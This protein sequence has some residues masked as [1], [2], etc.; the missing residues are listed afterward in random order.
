VG[1]LVEGQATEVTLDALPNA[2]LTGSVERIAPAA[3]FE[4]GV[5]YY[6]VVI[7]LDPTDVPVRADMTASATV[8]IDELPDVLM[9]PT[10]VVRV[11]QDTGQTYVD[12]QIGDDVERVDV[13]LG[14][15]HEGVAQVLS[16]LSE[17][18]VL[19]WV[20]DGRFDFGHP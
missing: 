12:R 20:D 18:D 11:D 17:G 14:V 8:V 19:V 15:R 16:G 10:W 3:T 7:E 13:T 5:V 9:I 6:D 2:T 1:R 4:G